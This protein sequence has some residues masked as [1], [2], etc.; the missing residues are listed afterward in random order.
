MVSKYQDA[1]PLYR[2][3]EILKRI[4]VDIP[5]ATLASWTIKT[6]VLVQPVINFLQDRLLA[7]PI[8]AMDETPVPVLK[9]P[10]KTAESQSYLWV[11]RG[12]PPDQ[13]I[14][15]FDYDPGRGA[16][17]PLRLLAGFKG[18]LQTDGYAG[19]NAV[20]RAQGLI[21]AGCLAHCRRKFDEVIKAQGKHRKKGLAEEGLAQIQKLYAVEKAARDFT[22][23]DRYAYRRTH[24]QPL[25]E[26]LHTWLTTHRPTVPPQT[27]LGKAL[28][29]LHNEWDKLNVYLTDGRVEIDNNKTENALRPFCVGRRNWLFSDTVAG[30]TA[31]ANL[32]SLIETCKANGLEPYAYLRRLFTELPQAET[33][34]AIEALLPVVIRPDQGTLDLTTPTS[35]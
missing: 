13:P 24:A 10:G 14:V 23:E 12:G 35:R 22:P 30:V 16:Q 19:Y 9:E 4:G 28:T 3:E 29:Y 7:Y 33:L 34:E 27:A 32:Y 8:L 20:V 17:V 6:G 5:R 11:Q 15:L 1:L 18:I 25:W 21:H 2:Q 31:S 26:S